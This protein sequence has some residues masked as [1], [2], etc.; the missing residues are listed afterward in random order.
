MAIDSDLRNW[1]LV[2][3]RFEGSQTI[4]EVD[5]HFEHTGSIHVRKQPWVSVA[6]MNG[7][8]RDPRVLRRIAYWMKK[9]EEPIR[10]YCVA[11]A[12][13]APSAGFRFVLGAVLLIQPISCPYMVCAT[14]DEALTFVRKKAA[15]R[16]LKLPAEL[17]SSWW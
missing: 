15:E 9:V 4:E 11:A 17:P 2:F 7:Y 14:L 3:T 13:V 12:M 8:G 1:P 5:A 6:I 16:A 10:Q